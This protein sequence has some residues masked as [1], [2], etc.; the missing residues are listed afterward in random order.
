VTNLQ[1]LLFEMPRP[2]VVDP[3]DLSYDLRSRDERIEFG[4][5]EF[6]TEENNELQNRELGASSLK[7]YFLLHRLLSSQHFINPIVYDRQNYCGPQEEGKTN[8]LKTSRL[9]KTFWPG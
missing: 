2:D 6:K 5:R 1:L 3:I 4:A 7:R 8:F 9:Y